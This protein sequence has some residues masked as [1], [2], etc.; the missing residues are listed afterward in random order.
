ML[1]VGDEIRQLCYGVEQEQ[2]EIKFGPE[3]YTAPG[4][5]QIV[6][7]NTV[8]CRQARTEAN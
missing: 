2:I 8:H 4:G 5:L 6:K 3:E 1:G 7:Y